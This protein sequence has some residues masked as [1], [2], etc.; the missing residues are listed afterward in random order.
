MQKLLYFITMI[1]SIFFT[2]QSL[3]LANPASVYCAKVGGKVVIEKLPSKNEIGICS[4]KH[5][6]ECEEWALFHKKCPIGGV[7]TKRTSKEERYCVIL[8]GKFSSNIC[9]I[10]NKNSCNILDLYNQ[11]CNKTTR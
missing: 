9:I 11:K 5:K 3:A 6:M 4:F 7:S 2:S 10:P 1:S 8:G